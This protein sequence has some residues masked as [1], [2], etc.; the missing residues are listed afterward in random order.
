MKEKAAII[1]EFVKLQE[2]RDDLLSEV[3]SLHAQLEQ[4]RSKTRASSTD[5][6]STKQSV[7]LDC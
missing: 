2:V 3:S 1:A 6:K 7:S 5:A 4:E